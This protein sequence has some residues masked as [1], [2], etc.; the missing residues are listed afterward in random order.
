MSATPLGAKGSR[1]L[2][3]RALPSAAVLM[4]GDTENGVPVWAAKVRVVDQPRSRMGSSPTCQCEIGLL[5]DPVCLSVTRSVKRLDF[6]Y[7]Q[8]G[9]ALSVKRTTQLTSRARGQ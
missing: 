5:D 2:I 3:A 9:W 1:V 6:E 8:H 4:S 7:G